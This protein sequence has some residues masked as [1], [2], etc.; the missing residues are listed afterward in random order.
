MTIITHHLIGGPSSAVVVPDGSPTYTDLLAEREKLLKEN[1]RLVEALSAADRRSAEVWDC[2][3]TVCCGEKLMCP[4]CVQ[5]H[6][7]D[8]DRGK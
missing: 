8:C 7:C 5:Y 3:E 2:L 1:A 4:K 6:P